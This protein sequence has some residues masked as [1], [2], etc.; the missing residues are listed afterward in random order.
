VNEK[1]NDE[2]RTLFGREAFATERHRRP[3]TAADNAFAHP[4]HDD[5]VREVKIM[6]RDS[7]A[8]V[9]SHRN[10]G[11]DEGSVGRASAEGRDATMGAA[12]F[13]FR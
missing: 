3:G 7:K 6:S 12:A 1:V 8:T 13:S 11:L 10:A 2:R 5:H 4:G 9:Q